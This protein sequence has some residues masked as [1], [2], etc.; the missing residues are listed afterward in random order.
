MAGLLKR[1]T[2]RK[3]E[4]FRLRDFENFDSLSEGRCDEQMVWVISFVFIGR[5]F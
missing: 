3:A 5:I 1:F 2:E 4:L